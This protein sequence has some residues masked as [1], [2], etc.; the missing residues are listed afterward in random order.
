MMERGVVAREDVLAAARAL[1]Q[2]GLVPGTPR[3]LVGEAHQQGSSV[4]ES[5]L[6]THVTS[7]MCSQA[8]DHHGTVYADLERVARGKYRIRH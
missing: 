8:P 7:R 5:T 3:Q 1:E 2:R 6:R 4:S